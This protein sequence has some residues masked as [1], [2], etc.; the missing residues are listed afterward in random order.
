VTALPTATVRPLA[1]TDAAALRGLIDAEPYVNAAIAA[2]L[3]AG[4]LA[5]RELVGVGDPLTAA[6]YVGGTLLPIGGE[7]P[8]WSALAGFLSTR[9]RPCSSIVGPAETLAGLWPELEPAWG[10]AREIRAVQP[11]LVLDRP[12]AIAS[13][14]LVRPAAMADLERY[15]PAAAAMFTEELGIAPLRGA[16]AHAFRTRMAE[17]IASGRALVRTDQHGHVL[18]KAEIAAVSRH[19]AQVQGVWMHPDRRGQGLGTPAMAAV[20]EHAL[21]L[22]PTVSLYVNDFNRPARRVY[23]RLGMRQVGT[24]S[25]VLF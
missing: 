19:T 1:S 4:P 3:A 2:R 6:C 5:G 25:T 16:R 14:P 10:P 9:P 20:V 24:V 13:D 7:A 21:R 22:A 8:E 17:L 18:F 12:P 11:L 15:L 23:E